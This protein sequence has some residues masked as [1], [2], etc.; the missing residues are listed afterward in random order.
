MQVK[1]LRVIEEG[2]VTRLGGHDYIPVNVRII[3]A[4]NKDLT[5]EVEDGLFRKDLF[6]RLNV[7]PLHLPA[8]RDRKEDI[9]MLIDF[10][11]RKLS[12]S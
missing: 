5:A 12:K 8:L 3:A 10:Y 2:V 4:T 9:P 1:L 11:S 7:L 6:Y